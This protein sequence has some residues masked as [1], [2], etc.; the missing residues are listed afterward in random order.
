MGSRMRLPY[1]MKGATALPRAIT[2]S[3]ML[4]LS[5]SPQPSAK[6]VAPLVKAPDKAPVAAKAPLPDLLGYPLKN[7]APAARRPF[8][9]IV[10][11][12]LRRHIVSSLINSMNELGFVV[13]KPKLIKES[14]KVAVVGKLSSG[15][16][17]RFDV[18]ES[19]EME[20]DM[21]GFSDRKCADHLDD[22]LLKLEENFGIESGP[23]Q[24]NWKNPDRISKGS[25]GF[26]TGG[27][28]RSLGGGN[29]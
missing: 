25:K 1:P 13:G 18:T 8:S 17:I 4:C 7:L 5:C 11:E 19:G 12:E 2:C 22:V 6:T 10:Q 21:E 29:R 26:P 3:L 14:R 27:N 9:E 23:V 20:F 28:T 15:R 24:H 16:N